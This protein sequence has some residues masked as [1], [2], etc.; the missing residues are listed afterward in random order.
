MSLKSF[1]SRRSFPKTLYCNKS[2]TYHRVFL[3]HYMQAEN[4]TYLNVDTELNVV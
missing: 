4:N 3:G 2:H 1:C